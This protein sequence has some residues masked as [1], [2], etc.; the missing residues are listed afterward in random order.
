MSKNTTSTLEVLQGLRQEA[1]R[2]DYNMIQFTVGL[3]THRELRL[4]LPCDQFYSH[5]KDQFMGIPLSVSARRTVPP[6]LHVGPS[7]FLER[8]N[9]GKVIL[10]G[11]FFEPTLLRNLK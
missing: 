7:Q 3:D 6:R 8:T 9:D 10:H 4:Q 1:L 2:K 5:D 11:Q